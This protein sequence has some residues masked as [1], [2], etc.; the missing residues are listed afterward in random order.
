MHDN[1]LPSKPQQEWTEVADTLRGHIAR[2][3]NEPMRPDEL[4]WLLDAAT[5][6]FAFDLQARS[7][8]SRLDTIL[9]N[10]FGGNCEH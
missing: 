3:A 4:K 7:F 8:D 1:D 5:I 2:L 10:H 9:G 6:S